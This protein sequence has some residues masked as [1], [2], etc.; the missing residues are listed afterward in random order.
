MSGP[1]P[2]ELGKSQCQENPMTCSQGKKTT[3]LANFGT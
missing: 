1:N 2:G 3:E